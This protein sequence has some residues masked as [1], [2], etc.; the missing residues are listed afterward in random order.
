MY[1]VRKLKPRRVQRIACRKRAIKASLVAQR[2][3][4]LPPMLETQVQS[5]GWE[6][7]LEKEMITLSSILAWRI[8]WTVK[9]GR[10]QSMGSH[11][12]RYDWSNLAAATRQNQM[13]NSLEIRTIRITLGCAKP[14]FL[15][16]PAIKLVGLFE[17][18]YLFWVEQRGGNKH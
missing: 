7:P 13:P 18:P 5:Q 15:R 4:R 9:P 6:D 8:P 16:K 11:R 1:L 17:N 10:L 2:L 14:S 3:K 12:V